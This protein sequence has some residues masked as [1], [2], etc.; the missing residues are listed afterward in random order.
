MLYDLHTELDRE[1]FKC[2][3]NI[4]YK[5]GV[6]V[7]LTE[8]KSQRTQRQNRYLHLILGWYAL[9]YGETLEF[10]KQQYFKKLCNKEIFCRK[11]SD[12]FLGEIEMLRST[13]DCD[14]AEL[15]IAID[16]FRAWASKECGIYLPSPEEQDFL[17]DIEIRMSQY[18]KY[19]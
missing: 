11:K 7:E 18:N 5:K 15:T 17:N 16:R 10:V 12:P 19:L 9:E 13:R 4:L 6:T 1:R 3:C 14:T 2:R 8:R